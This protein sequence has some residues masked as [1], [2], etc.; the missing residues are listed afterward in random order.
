METFGGAV[1][2]ASL[3]VTKYAREQP[4]YD[5]LAEKQPLLGT[6]E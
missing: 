4:P 1:Q 5:L 2:R 6:C 3:E